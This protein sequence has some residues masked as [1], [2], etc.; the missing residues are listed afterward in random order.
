MKLDFKP[1]F[2]RNQQL[3]NAFW[4]GKNK[5]P[6]ISIIVPKEGAIP[7]RKPEYRDEFIGRDGNFQPVI[8]QYLAWGETHDFVGEAIPFAFVEWGPDTFSSFLGA[9]LIFTPN[10][11]PETSWCIPFVKDWDDTEILF[12]RDSYWWQLSLAFF[13][14]LRAQC[15]EKLMI[16]PPSLVANL[17]SLA[18]IRGAQNLLFDLVECPEKVKKALQSINKVHKEILEEY[19]KILE[20][21]KYG[22]ISNEGTYCM[23]R[24]I[25]LQCDFSCMI[26]PEMFKDFVKPCLESETIDTEVTAYHLDGA[27]AIKHIE[28][29]SEIKKLDVINYVIGTGDDET[30][31]WYWLYKKIDDLGKGQIFRINDH[32]KIKQLWMSLESRKLFFVTTASSK[33]EAESFIAE[34]EMLEK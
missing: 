17:D 32:E 23:G 24:H 22:S 13:K 29:L 15:G 4:K 12:R 26:G 3:W 11:K 6:L 9:D 34:L 25:R 10:E 30:K 1:D 2:E 5:R 20:F 31:D 7:I 21:D 14:E 19:A 28:A 33:M 8:D 16:C 27:G 18:A